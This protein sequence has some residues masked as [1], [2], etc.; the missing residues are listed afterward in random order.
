MGQNKLLRFMD[1]IFLAQKKDVKFQDMEVQHL[2]NETI[3]GILCLR[4]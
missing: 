2:L 3:A 1:E 4:Q